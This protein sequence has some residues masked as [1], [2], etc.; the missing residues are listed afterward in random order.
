MADAHQRSARVLDPAYLEQLDGSSVEQLRTK[1]AECVELETEVSYVRR[2]TQARID[3]LEAEVQRR[4]SGG[5]FED[6]IDRLPQI[7]AD[8]GPRGNPASSRLPLQ[9]APQQDSEWAP[10]LQRFD[11]VL[12]NLPTLSDAELAEAI[13]GLRSLE[14]AVSDQ[15]RELFAVIDRI[16]VSLATQLR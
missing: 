8:P 2:L 12:A 10:E 5:S 7:L 13:A 1:H 3:I 9:M 4:S 15:R 16:D 6:L 14:R 11:G